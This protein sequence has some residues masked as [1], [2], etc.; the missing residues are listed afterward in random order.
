MAPGSLHGLHL[1]VERHRGR[2]RRARRARRRRQRAVPF[3]RGRPDAGARPRAAELLDVPDAQRS[4]RQHVAGPGG[5][6]RLGR[7]RSSATRSPRDRS[8]SRPV[9]AGG[10]SAFA[11]LTER[12]RRELHVH[13]YRML[14][15]FDEAEDAVQETF[16]RAWRARET[17]DGGSLVRA[18]L[19]RIATN[20]C[21]DALRRSARRLTSMRL[22]RRGA[23]AA[24][25]PRPPARRDRAE[26]TTS[27]TR[28]SSS[29]RPSSSRSSP[30]CRSCRR[31]S[32]PRSS[33]ATCSAGRRAR[34]R[35][36]RD[37]R[38]RPS[39]APSSGRARR[40][41]RTCRR[42]AP[43]GRR[44][45]RATRN[46][47]CSAVHR[48]PRTRRRGASPSSIAAQ[49]LRIT[50]PPAPDALRGA[51][52]D[53]A[54]A[55]ERASSE[56]ATG[57]CSRPWPTGCRRRRA[58]CARRATPIFRAFKFDVLR[59]VDG[60]IAEITTFGPEVFPQFGLPETLVD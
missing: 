11:A 46:G 22:V 55:R 34:R 32:A 42:A 26:P 15:S 12:Y 51:R 35:R 40:C 45:S 49:D 19:Y 29:A 43:T 8:A 33:R 24:A 7:R 38:R 56:A 16:L 47:P 4:R 3:R 59:V 37:V 13:C 52:V 20:V 60:R 50:M 10:E 31:A 53:R 27:P 25:V 14:A 44:A 23:V 17:F 2:A 58:T 5:Q 6:A 48:R 28:S 54:A 41:R 9:F 39:T 57:G 1:C 30:R 18:W 21:L 36:A